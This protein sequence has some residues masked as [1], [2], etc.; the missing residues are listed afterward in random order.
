[1]SGKFEGGS[2][3]LGH[4]SL[5]VKT[6]K[7]YSENAESYSQ[8]W[9]NQPEPTDMYQ[10]IQKYFSVGGETADIGC[11]N[12]RDSNWLVQNGFKVTGFDASNDLIKLASGIYPLVKFEQAFLPALSNVEKKFD[13]VLC[14]TVIMHLSKAQITESIQ[15][16]KRILKAGGVLYLSWRVTESEDARHADGRLYSAFDSQFVVD[17]FSQRSILHFEDKISTSSGK[18]VCRLITKKALE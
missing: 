11:G 4:P 10:L 14:E 16:F 1:M 18:R 5:D 15:S 9:L 7:A 3:H 13:N 17:Q 12:G 2:P 6:L 8:D